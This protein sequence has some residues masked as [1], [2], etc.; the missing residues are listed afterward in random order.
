MA[1][2]N[3]LEVDELSLYFGDPYVVNNYMLGAK[4][5]STQVDKIVSQNRIDK[6]HVKIIYDFNNMKQKECCDKILSKNG[7]VIE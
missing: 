4:V 5:K 7:K 1:N 3:L 6:S 2:E